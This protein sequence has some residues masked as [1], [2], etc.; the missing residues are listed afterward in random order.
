MC[1]VRGMAL[2]DDGVAV[3]AGAEWLKRMAGCPQ[4]GKRMGAE[5]ARTVNDFTGPAG[6][7]LE[8][9]WVGR[10]CRVLSSILY[11]TTKQLGFVPFKAR[12]P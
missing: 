12:Q 10:M 1:V 6:D 8:P 2:V 4:I 5:V 11:Q 9:I 7:G 3:L